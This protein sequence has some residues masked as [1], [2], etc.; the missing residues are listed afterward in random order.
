MM[1]IS[2]EKVLYLTGRYMCIMLQE[3]IYIDIFLPL[4]GYMHKLFSF[5]IPTLASLTAVFS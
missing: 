2:K 5:D 4:V 1:Y 3:C